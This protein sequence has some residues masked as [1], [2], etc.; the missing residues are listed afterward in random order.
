MEPAMVFQSASENSNF[1][2][3]TRTE[4]PSYAKFLAKCLPSRNTKCVWCDSEEE[5][6]E[7]LLG[8]CQLTEWAWDFISSWWNIPRHKLPGGT[9]TITGLLYLIRSNYTGKLW[10]IVIAAT[11]WSIWLSRNE[12]LF[13]N[14]R[15]NKKS[16]E[17]II[18]TRVNKWEKNSLATYFTTDPTWSINPQGTIALY[19]H[20]SCQTYWQY[21][22]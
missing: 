14:T 6:V 8:K 22:M 11:L 1:P 17:Y 12:T 20:K 13:G 7:H 21:K 18:L 3:E 4:S 5:T 2:M 9:P 16:L 15:V 19:L 10:K